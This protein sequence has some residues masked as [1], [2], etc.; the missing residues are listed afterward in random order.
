MAKRKILAVMVA[1]LYLCVPACSRSGDGK[2]EEVFKQVPEIAEIKPSI[3]VKIKL[4]RNGAGEYSWELSGDDTE[5][6]L[7][8]DR[9]L[10]QELLKERPK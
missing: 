6:V 9:R 5:K 10:K 8:A 4:K 2:P 1:V 7:Q 3:P